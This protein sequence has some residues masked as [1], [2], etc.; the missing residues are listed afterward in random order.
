MPS[1]ISTNLVNLPMEI[2]GVG[3]EESMYKSK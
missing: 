2:Y 3:N 1:E